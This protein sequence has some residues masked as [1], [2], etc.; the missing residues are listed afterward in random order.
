MIVAIK[1]ISCIVW[2]EQRKSK[3]TLR[4]DLINDNANDH[5]SVCTWACF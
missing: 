3:S 2:M 5:T 1:N 4:M